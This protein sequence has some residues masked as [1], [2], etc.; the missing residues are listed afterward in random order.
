MFPSSTPLRATV[1]TPVRTGHAPVTTGGRPWPPTARRRSHPTRGAHHRQREILE[2]IET[3]RGRPR[4]SP[5]GP[6]DRHGGR[7]QLAVDRSTP[8]SRRSSA[9]ATCGRTPPSPAP[10]RS[11]TTP[12]VGRH[13]R[14]G[15][16]PPRAP[17]RRRR[18][19]HRRAGARARRGDPPPARRLTG[20]GELFMLRVRGESMIEAGIFDGD[21]VVVRSQPTADNG[22]IVVAG[23][24]GEEAT[25]KTLPRQGDDDRPRSRP[26]RTMEPMTFRARR[27]AD[28][29]P[30]RHG[31]AQALRAQR[32]RCEPTIETIVSRWRAGPR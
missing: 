26:T 23:I 22:D 21:F 20:D 27:G 24:P 28:L 1:R 32:R 9:S 2:F 30:G 3:H 8:T 11:A 19:G 6:R 16:G 15:A 4:L 12:P 18:R 31:P 7:A 13:R 14:A 29:R 25:V 5:V 17:R 10:S